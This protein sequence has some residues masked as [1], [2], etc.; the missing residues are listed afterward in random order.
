MVLAEQGPGSKCY[1]TPLN[2]SDTDGDPEVI[3]NYMKKHP[4]SI[5]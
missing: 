5:I 1:L 3:E 4:V 2:I